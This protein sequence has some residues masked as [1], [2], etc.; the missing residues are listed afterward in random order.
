MYNF[1]SDTNL[2]VVERSLFV[3]LLISHQLV[4]NNGRDCKNSDCDNSG[5][6][7]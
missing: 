4:Q 5:L 7:S 1:I 3:S 2:V 6:K